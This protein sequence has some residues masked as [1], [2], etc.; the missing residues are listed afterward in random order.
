VAFLRRLRIDQRLRTEKVWVERLRAWDD[1]GDVRIFSFLT[2]FTR[3]SDILAV[4]AL[5]R[6][7]P[8][9]FGSGSFFLSLCD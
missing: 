9:L 6:L 1:S 4:L 7:H 8:L 2:V 3:T 5:L